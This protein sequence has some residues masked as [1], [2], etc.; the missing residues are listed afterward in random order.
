L[1]RALPCHGRGYG[2]EPRRSRHFACHYNGIHADKQ[3]D[4]FGLTAKLS[5]KT[6]PIENVIG[7]ESETGIQAT[8]NEPV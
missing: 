5:L 8:V 6:K 3:M 4:V 1:V 7:V 2:F